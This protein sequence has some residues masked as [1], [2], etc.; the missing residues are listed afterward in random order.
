MIEWYASESQSNRV[1]VKS[2]YD[3]WC[4]IGFSWKGGFQWNRDSSWFLSAITIFS[5]INAASATCSGE[6]KSGHECFPIFHHEPHQLPKRITGDSKWVN[7]KI[8]LWAEDE[9][10]KHGTA[11]TNQSHIPVERAFRRLEK[12][13]VTKTQI[14]RPLL[15]SL[16]VT[17]SP[18]LIIRL[19]PLKIPSVQQSNSQTSVAPGAPVHWEACLRLPHLWMNELFFGHYYYY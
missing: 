2:V 3:P 15:S 1:N 7:W 12:H 4:W 13:S 14:S 5:F 19:P 10:L 11:T 9:F 18:S 17:P 6:N 8:L 16:L